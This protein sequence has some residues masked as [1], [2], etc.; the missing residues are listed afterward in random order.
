MGIGA[1][2][3]RVEIQSRNP[4]SDGAGGLESN[5]TTVETRR[6]SIVSKRGQERLEGMQIE[7]QISHVFTFRHRT[8]RSISAAQRL[9]FGDRIF[10]INTVINENERDKFLKVFCKEGVSI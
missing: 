1:M 3:H 10:N 9:K 7:D 8:D 5:W 2:R 4:T 6:A